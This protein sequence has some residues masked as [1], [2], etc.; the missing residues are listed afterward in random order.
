MLVK[1][2]KY[3]WINFFPHGA[4]V[5]EIMVLQVTAVPTMTFLTERNSLEKREL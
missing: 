5:L 4:A 2:A 3:G 1:A